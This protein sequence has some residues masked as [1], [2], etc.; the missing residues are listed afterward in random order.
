MDT[1]R[2][3]TQYCEEIAQVGKKHEFEFN[4]RDAIKMQIQVVKVFYQNQCLHYLGWLLVGLFVLMLCIDI[5]WYYK[6]EV[7][8]R[9]LRLQHPPQRV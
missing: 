9:G 6:L 2:V 3:N 7:H 1:D 4:I 5:R 8:Q